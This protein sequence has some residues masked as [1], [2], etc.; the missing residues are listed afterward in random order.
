[1]TTFLGLPQVC[2]KSAPRDQFFVAIV[3][4]NFDEY[5]ECFIF[6]IWIMLL[7]KCFGDS[8]IVKMMVGWGRNN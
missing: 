6:I 3:F 2:L 5:F 8:R 7:K 1:M 4:K